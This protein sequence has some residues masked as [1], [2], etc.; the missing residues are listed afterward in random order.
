M[1]REAEELPAG[2]RYIELDKA[3]EEL[4]A[5]WMAEELGKFMRS[6]LLTRLQGRMEEDSEDLLGG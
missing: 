5:G 1:V 3:Y 2:W 6:C 4:P